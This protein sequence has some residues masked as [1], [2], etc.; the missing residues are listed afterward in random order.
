L[1][2]HSPG[3][4]PNPEIEPA[5]PALAG[6]FFPSEPPGKPLSENYIQTIYTSG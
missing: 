6:G 5:P 3:E 4:L 1:P 2:F